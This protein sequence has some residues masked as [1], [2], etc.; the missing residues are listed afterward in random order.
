MRKKYNLNRRSF[1]KSSA[2]LTGA[3]AFGV[4]NIIKAESKSWVM[5]SSF[6]LTGPFAAAGSMGLKYYLDWVEM[7][8]STG[9]IAGK[10][11]PVYEDSAYV[12]SKSAN[13][14]A[15]SA[16]DKPVFYG[17]DSTGL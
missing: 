17:G 16:D 5:A 4:P 11:K 12:P 2:A 10:I 9:G 1:L 13:F 6:P 8:N 14:K 3:F 15:M 7:T